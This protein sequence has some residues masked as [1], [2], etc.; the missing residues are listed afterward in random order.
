MDI[1]KIIV[2][3]GGVMVWWFKGN[4]EIEK[5][6]VNHDTR[7]ENNKEDIQQTETDIRDLYKTKVDKD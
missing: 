5:L 7:I 6:L 3:V 2:I 4:T 1:I